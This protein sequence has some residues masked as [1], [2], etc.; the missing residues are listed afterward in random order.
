M[1]VHLNKKF[2]E[3]SLEGEGGR[4]NSSL[5]V[6][7]GMVTLSSLAVFQESTS[8]ATEH[9]EVCTILFNNGGQSVI[10]KYVHKGRR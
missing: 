6:G 4:T 7:S 8:D 1:T 5:S 9:R 3:I 10:Y 2:S